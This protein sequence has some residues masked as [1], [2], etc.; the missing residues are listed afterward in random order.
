MNGSWETTYRTTQWRKRR[1]Y[2]FLLPVAG[3]A[4]VVLVAVAALARGVP[5]VFVAC[6]AAFGV[7]MAGLT[8][9]LRSRSVPLRH[10][11][12]GLLGVASVTA[13]G[14]AACDLYLQPF[15][16]AAGLGALAV[17]LWL[18]LIQVL[19]FLMLADRSALRFS[20][21]LL[22]ALAL[23]MLPYLVAAG[24]DGQRLTSGLLT[25]QAALADGALVVALY[26][27]SGFQ[28]RLRTVEAAAHA[29]QE[30]ANT[31]AL[32]GVPNRRRAEQSLQ[33]E[34]RRSQRYARAL[35][36]VLLDLDD[37]K[38]LNDVHGHAVGDEVLVALAERLSQEL[39]S[40]DT[41]GRWG[42][43]EFLVVA[44]ETSL[45]DAVTLAETMRR[46][47]RQTPLV[48]GHDVSA[49]F[50][51]AEYL[52][53]EPVT[54]LLRRADDA[55]YLAKRSGKDCVRNSDQVTATKS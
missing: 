33:L 4:A 48:H 3:S 50:G 6:I 29:M 51:V 43:E 12:L 41:F 28:R 17:V 40:S 35:S 11:E 30:L 53:G 49:S 14:S 5:T 39:R 2:A 1:V 36:V 21:G 23:L 47:V 13:L 20:F 18:P 42:G 45:S 7:G 34:M 44:P 9:A 15:G 54:D 16:A 52:P 22:T 31:D 55:L 37:F 46:R 38:R 8:V 24:G 32:T 19:A 26:V 10:V 27:L 25:L